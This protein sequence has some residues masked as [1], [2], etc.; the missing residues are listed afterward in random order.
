MIDLGTLLL[1][2]LRIFFAVGGSFTASQIDEE[3]LATLLDA[4]F[5][6]FDLTDGMASARRVVRLG[7][8]SGPHSVTLVNQLNYLLLG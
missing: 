4:F 3:E 8:V 2:R 7:G 1:A 6:D 5:L